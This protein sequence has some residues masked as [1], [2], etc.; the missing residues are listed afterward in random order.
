MPGGRV[1]CFRPGLLPGN[2]SS[3]TFRFCT[4]SCGIRG[5]IP[6]NVWKSSQRP[7]SSRHFEGLLG[8]L[9]LAGAA[10]TPAATSQR[11]PGYKFVQARRLSKPP[12]GLIKRMLDHASCTFVGVP[13]G[14]GRFGPLIC[15]VASSEEGFEDVTSIA[16]PVVLQAFLTCSST[17]GH[18]RLLA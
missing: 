7:T 5:Y 1:A 13:V 4:T 16:R 12:V 14:F 2:C 6:V 10:S 15:A 9:A 11:M 3:V 18:S 17:C 8:L